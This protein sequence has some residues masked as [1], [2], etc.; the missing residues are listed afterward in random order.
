MNST[1]HS[2]RSRRHWLLGL[3]LVSGLAGLVGAPVWL[4]SEGGSPAQSGTSSSTS[5]ALGSAMVAADEVGAHD[6]NASTPA[7]AGGSPAE[8]ARIGQLLEQARRR[9]VPIQGSARE[10]TGNRGAT[11]FAQNPAQD[12]AVRFREGG[13]SL[14]S[15]GS[16]YWQVG[17][18]YEG[19]GAQS[20]IGTDG[21]RVTYT[22]ADGVTEW[23]DNRSDG[24]EHSFLLESRLPGTE[25]REL[26]WRL[27]GMTASSE[28]GGQDLEWH[29]P[30]TG[31]ELCY[32]DLKVWDAAGTELAAS[33]SPCEGGF[34]ISIDDR[35]AAY[36]IFVDPVITRPLSR[37]VSLPIGDGV[38]LD[39]F[40]KSVD[41]DGTRLIVGAWCDN[42]FSGSAYIFVKQDGE[43]YYEDK[44]V[45]DGF[46]EGGDWLAR[47]CRSREIPP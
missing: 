31:T 16:G 37:M 29:R 32:S 40:G 8:K 18:H 47:A 10:L 34:T 30:D 6:T 4:S 36:P 15:T 11:H 21:T 13:I 44:L 39:E 1:P 12:L 35:H 38:G 14:D 9:I 23:F 27:E 41:T 28:P 2:P 19:A 33:M 45:P 25:R 42:N 24:L 26:K 5:V 17:L 43:W 46:M 20:V 3:G 22:H 7:A